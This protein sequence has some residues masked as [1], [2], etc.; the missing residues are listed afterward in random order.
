MMLGNS[1][2]E[3][4][5]PQEALAAYEQVLVLNPEYEQNAWYHTWVGRAYR[6]DG[7]P[8]RAIQSYERAL[9]LE[10]TNAEAIKWLDR[11]RP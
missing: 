10:E 6:E 8:Q 2:V 9:V 5:R 4:G 3:A 11:L 1:L 7:D